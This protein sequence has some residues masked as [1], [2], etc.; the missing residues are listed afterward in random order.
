MGPV[1]WESKVGSA[2][3]CPHWDSHGIRWMTRNHSSYHV[4][5]PALHTRGPRHIYARKFTTKKGWFIVEVGPTTIR[6]CHEMWW[7][8]PES[9]INGDIQYSEMMDSGG[10]SIATFYYRRVPLLVEKE[11]PRYDD[12][13]WSF[14]WVCWKLVFL[15][16]KSPWFSSTS[17][18][19][20]CPPNWAILNPENG[21][22][23]STVMGM[24]MMIARRDFKGL[25]LR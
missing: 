3:I 23:M 4:G 10:F 8:W 19:V 24:I 11:M 14:I 7:T 17:F 6:T 15:P 13:V 2:M 21:S 18:P 5:W 1:P 20:N 25:M 16:P 22:Y 12:S 9:P